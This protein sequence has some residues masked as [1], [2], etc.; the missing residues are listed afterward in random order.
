MTEIIKAEREPLLAP[1]AVQA[2]HTQGILDAS[3]SK[4]PERVDPIKTCNT[5]PPVYEVYV[6]D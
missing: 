1:W 6:S 3:L 5:K 2:G 4:F